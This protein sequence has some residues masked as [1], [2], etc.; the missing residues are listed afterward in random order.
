MPAMSGSLGFKFGRSSMPVARPGPAH[1]QLGGEALR[2]IERG[3]R[4][5][6][7]QWPSARALQLHFE[8]QA[9][10]GSNHFQKLSVDC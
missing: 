2:S 8:S 4:R 10:I 3:N 5:I 9:L 6:H 7:H 1:R